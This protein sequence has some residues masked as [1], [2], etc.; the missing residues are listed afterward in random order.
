MENTAARRQLGWTWGVTALAVVAL[1]NIGAHS[2]DLKVTHGTAIH[3]EKYSVPLLGLTLVA[4]SVGLWTIRRWPWHWPWLLVAGALCKVPEVVR[5]EVFFLSGRPGAHYLI[6]AAGA[7]GTALIVLGVLC[8]AAASTSAPTSDGSAGHA[9][10]LSG[11]AVGTMLFGTVLVGLGWLDQPDRPAVMNYGF[12]GIGLLGGALAVLA[13][14]TGRIARPEA[15]LLTVRTAI[16]GTAAALLPVVLTVAGYLLNLALPVVGVP[17]SG[18]GVLTLLCACGLA[19]A[20]GSGMVLRAAAAGLVLYAVAAPVTLAI[21]FTAGQMT[22]VWPWAF[23]GLVGGVALG[24]SRHR[25]ALA[26]LGCAGLGLVMATMG[27]L[28]GTYAEMATDGPLIMPAEPL[29]ALV[30]ATA[31][32]AVTTAVPLASHHRALPVVL[33]PLLIGFVLSIRDLMQV[34]ILHGSSGTALPEGRHTEKWAVLLGIATVLLVVIAV[35]DA[36]RAAVAR[37]GDQAGEGAGIVGARH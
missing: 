18:A 31:T 9:A 15:P 29:I 8:A 3:L 5:S 36:R 26:A 17:T 22:V 12:A 20:L 30:V 11:M 1:F 10:A 19:L 28:T 6:W 35:L 25:A 21:Y 24:R 37:S 33:G 13:V 34:F 2:P 32:V 27:R 7:A 16:V 4:T 23:A 14:R